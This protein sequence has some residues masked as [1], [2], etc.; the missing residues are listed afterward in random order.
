MAKKP[1]QQSDVISS[2]E[3][4][5]VNFPFDHAWREKYKIPFGSTK[6]RE[7]SFFDVKFDIIEERYFEKLRNT[8]LQKPT[9]KMQLLKN[10][11]TELSIAKDTEKDFDDLDLSEFDKIGNGK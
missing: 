4:W 3:Q 11:V 9:N 1:F 6:H 10:K 8:S 2:I 7:M 5:N